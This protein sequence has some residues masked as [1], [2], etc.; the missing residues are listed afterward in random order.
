MLE[1]EDERVSERAGEWS[2]KTRKSSSH[3]GLQIYIL[4]FIWL[5][6]SFHLEE[7]G[8]GNFFLQS[9]KVEV[10]PSTK[11]SKSEPLRELYHI[12]ISAERHTFAWQQVQRCVRRF[13]HVWIYPCLHQSVHRPMFWKDK[14]YISQLERYY[15]TQLC[16]PW[17]SVKYE[18]TKKTRCGKVWHLLSSDHHFATTCFELA[19]NFS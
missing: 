2:H 14:K 5:S 11:R 1:W 16:T 6:L 15:F 4:R 12:S 19:G 10:V 17:Q 3:S 7:P 8:W 9:L 18:T 13:L